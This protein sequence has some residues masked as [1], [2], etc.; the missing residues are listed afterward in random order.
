MHYLTIPI[1]DGTPEHLLLLLSMTA[2][3]KQAAIDDFS[4]ALREVLTDAQ[5]GDNQYDNL[6]TS[7]AMALTPANLHHLVKKYVSGYNQKQATDML[8]Q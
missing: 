4:A 8:M 6:D 1:P 7:E 3:D 5:A 2:A